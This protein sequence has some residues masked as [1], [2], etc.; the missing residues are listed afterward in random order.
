MAMSGSAWPALS[1]SDPVSSHSTATGPQSQVVALPSS[2]WS[3]SRALAVTDLPPG[4]VRV[5]VASK[6]VANSRLAVPA[7]SA[8]LR[9]PESAAW[10]FRLSPA[11]SNFGRTSDTMACLTEPSS[12]VRLTSTWAGSG[13]PSATTVIGLCPANSPGRKKAQN[14][15]GTCSEMGSPL[16][17]S[18][19]VQVGLAAVGA[20]AAG[21]AGG[22]HAQR[23]AAERIAIRAVFAVVAA[24]IVV[25]APSSLA[26]HVKDSQGRLTRRRSGGTIGSVRPAG[27]F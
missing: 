8:A 26:V 23:N 11:A 2:A 6:S 4:N 15:I 3:M 12:K 10:Q 9:G 27:A 21:A 20:S 25:V 16:A 18:S 22:F 24:P 5:T 19:F 7:T 1:T 17:G 13:R 14:V